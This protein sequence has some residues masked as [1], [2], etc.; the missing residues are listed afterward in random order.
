[1]SKICLFLYVYILTVY[2]WTRLLRQTVYMKV[3]LERLGWEVRTRSGTTGSLPLPSPP[4]SIP[5]PTPSPCSCGTES[6]SKY[7]IACWCCVRC[8]WLNIVKHGK[9]IRTYGNRLRSYSYYLK[10]YGPTYF[11]KKNISCIARYNNIN[12]SSWSY[13]NIHYRNID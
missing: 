5:D 2:N 8:N 1:M 9:Q 7:S 4:S 11:L 10:L 3:L 6:Q 12:F 13:W